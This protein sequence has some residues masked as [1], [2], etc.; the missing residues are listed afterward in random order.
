MITDRDICM[1]AYTRGRTLDEVLVNRAMATMIYAATPNA[2]T[3]ELESLMTQHQ[4]HRIPIIDVAGKP[5]GMASLN[6]LAIESVRPKTELKHGASKIAHTLAA[7]CAHRD[8]LHE[9]V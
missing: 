4:L 2:T 6:D 5:V 8:A 1:A 3:A 7:I 9:A